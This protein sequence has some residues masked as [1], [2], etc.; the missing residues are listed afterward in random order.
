MH[1]SCFVRFRTAPCTSHLIVSSI[2]TGMCC[3]FLS[4]EPCRVS[5]HVSCGQPGPAPV[6]CSF[7]VQ[8]ECA[9]KKNR[10]PSKKDRHPVSIPL[11]HKIVAFVK[12]LERVDVV[13]ELFGPWGGVD[14]QSPFVRHAMELCPHVFAQ[15]LPP[16]LAG[17]K[18]RPSD[19]ALPLFLPSPSGEFGAPLHLALIQVIDAAPSS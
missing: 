19:L 1:H 10:H 6:S 2:C 18:G 3:A 4:Q 13:S 17:E 9:K 5:R 14:C 16:T 15:K 12:F 7:H 8:I 11:A